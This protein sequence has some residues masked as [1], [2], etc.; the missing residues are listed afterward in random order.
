VWRLLGVLKKVIALELWFS[1]VVFIYIYP[2][3]WA[4]YRVVVFKYSLHD[5][6]VDYW[7]GF[8]S[9][10]QGNEVPQVP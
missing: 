8:S 3:E 5:F 4:L 1:V 10:G 2:S 9:G 7:H 6:C